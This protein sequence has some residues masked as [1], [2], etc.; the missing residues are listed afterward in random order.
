[1]GQHRLDTILIGFHETPLPP[2]VGALPPDDPLGF[3]YRTAMLRIHGQ[4]VEPHVALS[5]MSNASSGRDALYHWSEAAPLALH[6]LTAFLRA[7]GLRAEMIRFLDGEHDRL[8][9]LLEGEPRSV[10]ILTTFYMDPLPILDAVSFIRRRNQKVKIILGGPFILDLFRDFAG[11]AM[12]RA[13]EIL[14][15]DVVVRSP[16]G[17]RTLAKVLSA[18]R[19]KRGLDGVPNLALLDAGK[20]VGQTARSIEDDE[21]EWTVD[22]DQLGDDELGRAVNLRTA[23]GCAF[24]C[25]FCE[26]PFRAGAHR[27]VDVDVVE[28]Q[29]QTLHR[30]GVRC[31]NFVDDTFNVPAPRF[32]QLCRMML[33]NRLDLVWSSYFRASGGNQPEL[34]RVMRQSGCAALHFGVESGDE[35]ML[36]LMNKHAA[37][38]QYERAIEQCHENEILCHAALVIGFPGETAQSLDT[39][40]RFVDRVRPTT[41]KAQPFYYHRHAPVQAKAAEFRLEGN[42]WY[43][44]HST[45]DSREAMLEAH[46]VRMS[47]KGSR[48]VGDRQLHLPM[49]AW[50]LSKGMSRPQL[51]ELLTLCDEIQRASLDSTG[52]AWRGA[53]CAQQVCRLQALCGGLHLEP[54]RF[55]MRVVERYPYDF[56]ASAQKR[57]ALYCEAPAD[58]GLH[59]R[60]TAV[61]WR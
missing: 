48:S 60:K 14:G 3:Y 6:S 53:S 18:L 58:R 46:R 10:C 30:R 50:L 28:S 21:P 47:I 54:S 29:L 12:P 59:G 39:T 34:F 7:H 5:R 55:S 25:D 49:L 11:D 57:R 27:M 8:V 31:I 24:T 16:T 32:E 37:L 35:R 56:L 19:E 23:I 4:D 41:F 42:G 22:W 20:L 15:A 33:R 51:L 61:T 43:W 40:I 52:A 17:E 9:E 44:R 1:M 38:D 45:M 2:M 36:G 13:L 26:Y